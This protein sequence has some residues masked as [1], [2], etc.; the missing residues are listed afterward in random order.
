MRLIDAEYYETLLLELEKE[1][2]DKD[3]KLYDEH[4][5]DGV[6]DAIINLYRVVYVDAVPTDWIKDVYKD[7]EMS[8]SFGATKELAGKMDG[9]SYLLKL[10]RN[11]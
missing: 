8:Y 4:R 6:K 5:A 10:W 9:I 3:G 1:Y 2:R 7:L 11:K